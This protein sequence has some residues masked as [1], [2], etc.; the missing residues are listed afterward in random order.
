MS[1]KKKTVAKTRPRH[2]VAKTR[3]RRTEVTPRAARAG[4]LSAERYHELFF[5]LS[6]GVVMLSNLPEDP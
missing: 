3:P 6:E 1:A 2:A 4:R 5:A